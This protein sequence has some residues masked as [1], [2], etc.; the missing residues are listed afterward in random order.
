[1]ERALFLAA[2]DGDGGPPSPPW[3]KALSATAETELINP[4]AC[5]GFDGMCAVEQL[6]PSRE[7]LG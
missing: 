4:E 5:Q 3:K 2:G 7:P 1:M 6:P